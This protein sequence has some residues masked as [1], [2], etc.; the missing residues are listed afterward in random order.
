ML[1]VLQCSAVTN[2]YLPMEVCTRICGMERHL[3]T[4]LRKILKTSVLNKFNHR[5]DFDF[6]IRAQP[7]FLSL[8]KRSVSSGC[9]LSCFVIVRQ[10]AV[11]S[12]KQEKTQTEILWLNISV[13]FVCTTQSTAFCIFSLS[14]SLSTKLASTSGPTQFGREESY[15]VVT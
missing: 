12:L 13:L 9:F 4:R 6:F 5:H 2:A 8:N 10:N 14:L 3:R 1:Y 15:S 11:A 7:V